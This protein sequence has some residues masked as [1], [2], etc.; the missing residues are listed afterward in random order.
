[1]EIERRWVVPIDKFIDTVMNN[2]DDVI[3]CGM[4][5]TAYFVPAGKNREDEHIR[6]R[7][8][9]TDKIAYKMTYKYGTGLSRHEEE[10][11][12]KDE[13]EFDRITKGMKF[14]YNS[15]WMDKRND[16]EIKRVYRNKEDPITASKKDW[17]ILEKEFESERDAKFYHLPPMWS[18][19]AV[20]VT[21]NKK[22]NMLYI[23][24]KFFK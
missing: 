9:I 3:Y 16:I 13:E 18:S 1:M 12:F 8:V 17:I 21:D 14:I 20:D 5:S 11:H 2:K 7:K 15:F 22:Y 10:H 19:I 6:Y 4:I 23:Y 24:K